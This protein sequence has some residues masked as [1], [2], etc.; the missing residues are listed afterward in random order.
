M[1]HIMMRGINR[2]SIFEDNEDK[3]RF[4]DTLMK[5]I[6]QCN[7][8]LYAYCLMDNHIHLLL[9]ETDEPLSSFIKKISS[10]YVH[11]Y[12]RKYKRCGH[13]FQDRFKSENVESITY[14]RTVLRYIHQNPLKAGLATEV[15][16]CKWTSIHEYSKPNSILNIKSSLEIFSKDHTQALILFKDYMNQPSED[17][18]MEDGPKMNKTDDEVKVYLKGIGISNISILQQMDKEKRNSLLGELKSLKGISERQLSRITGISRSII[19]Q[20]K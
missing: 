4:L 1:Y 10:S 19:R 16:Q 11:W 7:F 3:E 20:V 8:Q 17:Q 14:F 12:N 2:Q 13:L 18:C 6:Q 5:Y 9:K 15:F